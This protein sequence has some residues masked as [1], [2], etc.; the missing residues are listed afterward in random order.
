MMRVMM[1]KRATVEKLVNV[2]LKEIGAY[3]VV[4]VGWVCVVRLTGVGG[5]TLNA[6]TPCGART[7]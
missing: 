6:L 1:C 2:R 4:W 5:E 7:V 3:Y